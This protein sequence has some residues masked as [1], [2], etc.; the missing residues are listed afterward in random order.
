M[1]KILVNKISL[2]AF[3]LL[4]MGM[5]SAQSLT[6][7]QSFS[8]ESG[9]TYDGF[10]SI[11][12]KND[13][14]I[15][16]DG[17]KLY[18]L[19][20]SVVT[21][22]TITDP[23][24][25]VSEI[26]Q[27]GFYSISEETGA[28]GV[29][30]SA[31]GSKM[32][33]TGYSTDAVHQY[34]LTS[35]FDITS[36]VTYDG[37]PFD[38]SGQD[39]APYDVTFSF[40]GMKMFV[41]GF[42]GDK[43]LQYSL[44][45]PFDITSGVTYDGSPLS[46]GTTDGNARG[47][48]FSDNGYHLF[49]TGFTGNVYRFNLSSPFDLTSTV[50][51]DENSIYVAD[52]VATPLTL[53]LSNNGSQLYI[54][55][56]SQAKA[57]QYQLS[58]GS[59]IEN[60][61]NNGTIATSAAIQIF[62]ESFTNAG[63][64][65]TSGVDFSI[66]N[67]PTGLTPSITVGNNGAYGIITLTGT[68]SNHQNIHDISSLE[69]TFENSAFVGGDAS[70]VA[71][72]TAA[73]S[74]ISVDFNDNN[75]AVSYSGSLTESS[76]NNG[77]VDGSIIVNIVDTQFAHAGGTMTYTT[78]YTLVNVP[79][80]LTPSLSVAADGYSATLTFS[81]AANDH[82]DADD[83]SSIGFNFTNS[84]FATETAANV[85][86]ATSAESGIGI[87]FEE[88]NS[89]IS[90]GYKYSLENGAEFSTYFDPSGDD[91]NVAGLAFNDDGTKMFI[92]GNTGNAILQY[93]LD[94]PYEIGGAVTLEGSFDVSSYDITP[95]DVIFNPS[96][97]KMYVV[98]LSSNSIHQFSLSTPYDLTSGV[99]Y[100][101]TP[102]STPSYSHSITFNNDGT[103]LFIFGGIS[104]GSGVN[105]YELNTP[106]DITTG[107]TF[108]TKFTIGSLESNPRGMAFSDN[109][110]NMFL[111]GLNDNVYRYSLSKPF[112]LTSTVTQ[113]GTFDMN[114][115]LNSA[116]GLVFDATGSRMFVSSVQSSINRISEFKL[117]T[118]GFKE[119]AANNGS[120]DGSIVLRAFDAEFANAGGTLS[121]PSDYSV[122]GIPAGLT[123]VLSVAG[124]GF[125][126]TLTLSGS[127]SN[128]QNVNDIDDLIFTLNSS[129]F[130]S[131]YSLIDNVS[132]VNSYLGIDF[133]NN[134]PIIV[135][136]SAY[137]ILGGVTLNGN[138]TVSSE[139]TSG[140]G[141]AFSADGNKMFVVGNNSDNVHQYTLTS[142]FDPSGGITLDGSYNI[143]SED[144]FA[145][146][147][148]F[149]K[150]GMKMFISGDD[151]SDI[152][153]YSL[154]SAFDITSGVTLVGSF[155]STH[156]T[157]PQGVEFSV[158]GSSMFILGSSG[159]EI[160]QY[161]LSTPFD[162]T[163]GVSY[164]TTYDISGEETSPRDLA[165]S[166]DGS[167]MLI[168]GASGRDVTQYD[169]SVP[170]NLA[171]GVTPGSTY[172][173]TAA[174]SNP[175]GLCF[176][177]DGDR[178]FVLDPSTVH[179]FD[180]EMG[181]FNET[182]INDGELEGSVSIKIVD[183][184]FINAGGTLTYNSEY[185]ITNLPAGL[186]PTLSVAG[187]GLSAT[188]TLSG[189]VTDHQE[190]NSV[191]GLV[192]TFAN[193]AFETYL[194]SEVTNAISANSNIALNFMDNNPA[195]TYGDFYGFESIAFDGSPY[196]VSGQD[197]VPT[198]ITFSVDGMKLFMT[199]RQN[200]AVY[201]YALTNA[202]DV[203]TGVTFEGSLD[204][205]VETRDAMDLQFSPDGMILLVLSDNTSSSFG[206]LIA[207]YS[208]TNPFDITAGVTYS[209]NSYDLSS[210][211]AYPSGFTFN[212][213]GTQVFI[214]NGFHTDERIHFYSLNSS[215]DIS[216]GLTYDGSFLYE[217]ENESLYDLSFN[218]DG[219]SLFVMYGALSDQI[220]ELILEAPYDLTG[221][222]ELGQSFS[223]TSQE[224]F[225]QGFIFGPNGSKLFVVGATGDEI[226]QYT[227]T[228]EGFVEN[229]ANDGSIDGL[230]KI[231]L[232]DDFFT[233]AGGTLSTPTNYSIG[234]LPAGLSPVLNVDADGQMATLTFTGNASS[235]LNAEDII[236]LE[237]TFENSAFVNYDAA[238]VSNA[239]SASSGVGID[240]LAGTEAEILTFSLADETGAA[241]IDDENFTVD[242]EV[243]FGTD[244]TS[245]TPTITISDGATI[246]PESDVQTDFTNTVTYTVTAEDGSQQ[247]WDVTVIVAPNTENDI[248]SFT[249]A[250]I[251][252]NSMIDAG[253]HTVTAQA[254]AGT[255]ISALTPTIGISQNASI[256]PDSGV[257]QDFTS[258]VIYTITAE[259]GGTQ[260]WD[261]TITE[262]E[263][264]P[265]DIL[266]T[267]TSVDENSSTGTVVAEISALDAN[268]NESFTYYVVA[269][270]G[271]DDWQSFDI[272][273][274][275]LIT[276]DF[277][278]LDFETKNEFTFEL[279]VRDS[280]NEAYSEMVTIT[281]N[282][283]NEAPT[284]ISLDN[285]TVDESNPAGNVVGGLSVI[286]EDM[287]DNHTYTLKGG[288]TDNASFD[289]NGDQLV[290]AV[291]LD[292]ETK[293]SY[294]VEVIVTDQGDL[295]YEKAF[296]VSVNDLPAQVTSITLSS[297]SID[298]NSSSGSTVGN[299]TT[300]GEDLSG[301]Y[302]YTLVAG[303][304][305]TDN[306]SF[307]ISGN[308]LLTAGSFDFE[309]QSSHSI[310]MMTDDGGGN[311]LERVFTINVNDVAE[312][313]S[314]ISLSNNSIAENNL[315][316]E[317]IGTLS[318]TD[319]DAGESYT[320]SL[321]T[322][323]GD[324]DNASFF[325][326]GD[327]LQAAVVFDFEIQSNY[328]IRV[329]TNDGN[330]GTYEE[331]F[332][333]SITNE[334]E[335][336]VVANAVED[337]SENEGF[338]ST[339]IDISNVFEDI[340]GDA[341]T[342]TVSSSS[343]AVV[344]V[345]IS[346]TDLTVTEAGVGFSTITV[347]A[348]DGS[349]VSTSDEF[350][351]TVEEAPLGLGDDLKVK[352]YPNPTVDF[353]NIGSSKSLDVMLIDLNGRTLQ[354]ANGQRIQLDLRAVE[355]G[356]YLLKISDG[357]STET[358]RIIKAN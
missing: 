178:F 168:V 165:F 281:L 177:N 344:T 110:F 112:D 262:V 318:T 9:A 259:D 131:D 122:T 23:Y 152:Y 316:S 161:S 40:D 305:D 37:S 113:I 232:V 60:E 204:I 311:T 124:D 33:I 102:F 47:F 277:I 150:D 358:K 209:G 83:V 17:S 343:T 201:Q 212:E 249:F 142:A 31:D 218:G 345:S 97:N 207:Q 354:S 327:E 342:Y 136:G 266:L 2:L 76:N 65:L 315:I 5:A 27:D 14:V 130:A 301:S 129:A 196:D 270:L 296:A 324:A 302:T 43:I 275:N 288:V 340:D 163:S 287:T 84:A 82:Q 132:G 154:S 95:T 230:L 283:V 26:T 63:G 200:D 59:F 313:P 282:D 64:T 317:V 15:S 186:T 78:D 92:V 62:D 216:G 290:T 32:F 39:S 197:I 334:N 273:G 217:V 52:N 91:T 156:D 352:V 321:V 251:D 339:V 45:S 30:F 243:T 46:Y 87:D 255:D 159:I 253:A 127:A 261:V 109:G 184:Q 153:Q 157:S 297:E 263:V 134:N 193:S 105:Q 231:K 34:S 228:N 139:E 329:Q 242:I 74:G 307:S 202:F 211:M 328:S 322:G 192:F 187:D 337:Q 57:H 42:T 145:S 284:D 174:T 143:S 214:T 50:S 326:V 98:G 338:G 56:L 21:Q 332:S 49:L 160:N 236:S 179:Q 252:G 348:D 341:L 104:S 258:T 70:A 260:D 89:T 8:L 274:S 203:T 271:S 164:E 173:I 357:E 125:S 295:T 135:Y 29:A 80:G 108:V 198:N 267:S 276:T 233:N 246:S 181:G 118:G 213:N 278:S 264:A 114:S 331:A 325:I 285:T 180:I 310:R 238:D 256:S 355:A 250:E 107:L 115:S 69:F 53:T 294:T 55:E 248:E 330:G 133:N 58:T 169:L 239:V 176:D 300:F 44:T 172:G 51:L 206:S 128:H 227:L 306:N 25:I 4:M 167:K 158:D 191:K 304:G 61:L 48:E 194:A 1:K 18:T 309:T 94:F 38:V 111:V 72:A 162:I 336:V 241:S 221:T 35:A 265:T 182:A 175:R 293:S 222:I 289:I 333:I 188:L 323:T 79:S 19:S 22:Y 93:S 272:D 10:A 99:T 86:N 137:D 244:V 292:F 13:I 66:S 185:T 101:D 119:A 224:D 245:L 346:G 146:G 170:F 138:Q 225:P 3:M 350:I 353:L 235:H 77:E 291:E 247:D 121:S 149:S 20:N 120:V 96:G 349:G 199:G 41:M 356:M 237:F 171:S 335:G 229:S 116:T 254:V 140:T 11:A 183:D 303:T 215:Y 28:Q 67:L 155:F 312:A 36:T 308:Q 68:A 223:V 219:T 141:V 351:F 106:Y 257:A 88:N 280:E 279:E 144:G 190:I 12:G 148:T 269:E 24:D 100:D 151:R 85:T 117:N 234:N 166:S 123:P 268:F 90:Y 319:E 103:T 286:D 210:Q 240:F 81:G 205:S 71:N 75:P 298:E 16:P 126:A 54:I 220:D 6:Y 226:N 314:D 195:L 73:S 147:I 347:Y 320:Y 7:Q 208:L 299:M 189:Q